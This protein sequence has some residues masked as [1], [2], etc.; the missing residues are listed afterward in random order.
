M[1]LYKSQLGA[2]LKIISESHVP[3]GPVATFG[4]QTIY[5]SIGELYAMMLKRGLKPA[6]VAVD[7]MAELKEFYGDQALNGNILLRLLGFEEIVNIDIVEHTPLTYKHNLGTPLPEEMCGRF[8]LVL[9]GTTGSHVADS[10]ML[11]SNAVRLLKK[12]GMVVHTCGMYPLGACMPPFTPQLLTSFYGQ[13]GF[14]ELKTFFCNSVH[15]NTYYLS[16]GD[17]RYPLVLD[18]LQ[19]YSLLFTAVKREEIPLATN[20]TE[21]LYWLEGKAN[22]PFD[23]AFLAG[24]KVAIWGS[25][26]HYSEHYKSMVTAQCK[27]FDVWGFVDNDKGKWGSSIDGFEIH[28]PEDLQDSGV[29]VVL[30]ATWMK[31]EVYE[32]LCGLMAGAPETIAQ[33]YHAYNHVFELK[34]LKDDYTSSY[35]ARGF[36][37][38]AAMS[39]M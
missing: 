17:L 16:G 24:K 9:D 10:M 36:M 7:G 14:E 35:L 2:F 32:Q 21:Y 8:S 6:P 1:G 26:G 37:S 12:D 19:Q 11:L 33:T 4:T 18:N 31:W 23:L 3:K 28:R 34:M 5:C 15:P 39:R 25:G 29:D 13:N 20:P 38:P 30:L 22:A 27:D